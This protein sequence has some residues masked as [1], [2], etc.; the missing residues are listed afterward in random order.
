VP[1]GLAA[2]QRRQCGPAQPLGVLWGASGSGQVSESTRLTDPATKPA[3]TVRAAKKKPPVQN[4]SQNVVLTHAICDFD[5]LAA[6]V[7][8][9][10]LWTLQVSRPTMKVRSITVKGFRRNRSSGLAIVL[11]G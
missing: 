3:A 1:P 8:L 6:A 9:A 2:P 7:G 5:S 11:E 10:K 4:V